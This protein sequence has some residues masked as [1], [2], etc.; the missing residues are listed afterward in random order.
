[1]ILPTLKHDV[2]ESVR[3]SLDE[4]NIDIRV[5]RALP[6]LY[7]DQS[8]VVE[9]FRNL[10]TNAM[11]YNDK[12]EK[13]IEIGYFWQGEKEWEDNLHRHNGNGNRANDGESE[14]LFYVRDNGIGIREKHIDSIFRIFKRLHGRDKY[15]GGTG[16]GLTIVKKIIERHSGRIWVES[17]FGEGTTFYFTLRGAKNESGCSDHEPQAMHFVS[18]G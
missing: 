14:I 9:V 3:V 17:T 8:R 12:P 1:L 13:W 6:T 18:G 2:L 16:A 7:C 15:G 10:V 4:K 11:K 5:P